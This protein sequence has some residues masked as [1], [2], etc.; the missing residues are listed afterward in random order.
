MCGK[1]LLWTHL[2]HSHW[3]S[4]IMVAVDRLSTFGNFIPLKADF[5]RK[6]VVE[7]FVTSIVGL[8]GFLNPW[9]Q[10]VIRV[11]F[12]SFYNTS[13]KHKVPLQL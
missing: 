2:P 11:F 12:S 9:F 5:T 1:T 4:T 8:Y 7:S 10:N 3:Y 13:L 6:I